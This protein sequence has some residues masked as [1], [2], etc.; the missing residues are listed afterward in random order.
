MRFSSLLDV[1]IIA[2]FAVSGVLMRPLPVDVM[3]ALLAATVTF[4]LVLDQMK[5]MLFRRFRID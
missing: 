3:L 1:A 4:I 2:T 5:A